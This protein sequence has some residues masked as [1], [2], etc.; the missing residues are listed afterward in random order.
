V[1]HEGD[2]AGVLQLGPPDVL[3]GL[4]PSAE[5]VELGPLRQ[6]L[7]APRI[8][9]GVVRRGWRIRVVRIEVVHEQE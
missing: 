1:I 4:T 6:I 9:E 8:V 5:L 2:L 3:A 7:A